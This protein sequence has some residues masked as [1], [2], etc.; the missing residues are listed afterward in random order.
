[1]DTLQTSL[2][3]PDGYS[4]WV[5][6]LL[7]IAGILLHNILKLDTLNRQGAGK[8]NFGKYIALERFTILASLIVVF[9]GAFFLKKE[10]GQN[11][12]LFTNWVGIGF[13]TLGYFA[14]SILTRWMGAAQKY[15]DHKNKPD[16]D[17][18]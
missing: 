3:V 11:F 6:F 18:P 5:L 15:L 17:N 13:I 8:I 14:T 9:L 10:L 16:T 7:G 12:E 4:M 1:M 2:P